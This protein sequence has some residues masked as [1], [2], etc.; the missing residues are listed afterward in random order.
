MTT[1]RVDLL[2]RKIRRE[3]GNE[4][5]G[6]TSGISDTQIAEYIND[7]IHFLSRGINAVHA[8]QFCAEDY[9]SLVSGQEKYDLPANFLETGGV[10]SVEY[11][12]NGYNSADPAWIP[13]K[14][15]TELE[16]G[17][18]TRVD[19]PTGY[20]VMGRQLWIRSI[21][22][23]S[24]TNALRVVYTKQLTTLDVRRGTV[25][26]VTL[27]SGASSITSLTITPST[28]TDPDE[29]SSNEYI[30]VVDA[31]GVQK[32]KGIKITGAY[33]SGTGAI[34]IRSGFTYASGET[35][36]VGDYIVFGRDASTHQLSLN[37]NVESF[38]VEYGA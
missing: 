2:I 36:A 32:M 33:N 34:T 24:K 25:S 28:A 16:R 12:V 10:I 8:K 22:S 3:T 19:V 26:A 5:Y 35:I 21:P 13:L 29:F 23:V 6:P 38:L 14:E 15:L 27:N 30:C 1:R 20:I 4:D 9:I 17:S 18:G 7:G 37:E 11:T 31:D